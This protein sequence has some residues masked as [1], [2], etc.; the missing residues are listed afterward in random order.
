MRTT[1]RTG[2]GSKS[3]A[4]GTTGWS[5]SLAKAW[6]VASAPGGQRSMAAS[7]RAMAPA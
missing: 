1:C 5:S 7:P 4:S 3:A 6:M 2:M